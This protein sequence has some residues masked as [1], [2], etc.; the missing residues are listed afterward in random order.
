MKNKILFILIV[1]GIAI[2]ILSIVGIAYIQLSGGYAIQK[3]VKCYDRLNNE[4]KGLKCID[5][6]YIFNKEYLMI[7]CVIGLIL[8]SSMAFIPAEIISRNIR[9]EMFYEK[10]I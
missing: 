9:R 2:D 10:K 5:E 7:Y 6:E 1:I 4:I 3:E 8:G